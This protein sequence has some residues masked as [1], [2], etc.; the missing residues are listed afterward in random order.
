MSEE[1]RSLIGPQ[2]GALYDERLSPLPRI[3]TRRAALRDV[4]E[5]RT[6]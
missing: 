3:P 4:S 6:S 5:R 2:L 1:T